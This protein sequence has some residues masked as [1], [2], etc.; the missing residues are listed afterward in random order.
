MPKWLD[1]PI[2]NKAI[3]RTVTVLNP[4]YH[5]II[6]IIFGII[7]AFQWLSFGYTFY[8]FQKIDKKVSVMN[9]EKE[10]PEENQNNQPP[11]PPPS[12]TCSQKIIFSKEQPSL[13]F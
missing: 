6:L 8:D 12:E 1:S 7:L 13:M 5:R 10:K 4:K 3:R 2:V 11:P 9:E